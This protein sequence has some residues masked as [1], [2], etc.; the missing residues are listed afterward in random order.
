[1]TKIA[2]LPTPAFFKPANAEK[3]DYSP[4]VSV[5]SQAAQDWAKKHDV[6]P[7]GHDKAK[8]HLLLID[9]QRD[10]CFPKGTLYVGGR[11][12][13]GAI[14]DSVR[15]CEF[16]Y[17]NLGIVTEITCTMDT[18]FPYQIFFPSFWQTKDGKGAT[19]HTII[20]SEMI[21][22]G[23]FRPTPAAA[24]LTCN[25]AYTWL[26]SYVQHYC[27]GL[28]K[29]GKY[30]LYLWPY[31]CML[32]EVGHALVGTIS[33]ARLFH[34][35]A[36]QSADLVEVKGGNLLTE[37]YS[38]LSPEILVAHEGTPIAQRNTRFIKTLL[39]ADAIV[40]AGQAASHCV[41]SSI[42]DLLT[43]IQTQDP[44]LT[45][46]VYILRDCMSAVAVPDGKGGFIADF[47][48]QAVDALAKFQNAGMHVVES[49]TPIENWDGICL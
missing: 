13:K 41:K 14:E 1:M 24:A 4:D 20:K 15:I 29:S 47:T 30:N 5:V 31:H 3:W 48:Q 43:S 44:K 17:Q 19:P 42:E 12:G 8:I 9:E 39:E 34:A 21:K 38:V 45:K 36:R 10:F 28:E 11:S 37:N 33:E 23:E 35:F 6:K 7:S 26:L 27:E 46:K 25:G 40:I 2:K 16:I 32:G 22:S 49:T 18:H